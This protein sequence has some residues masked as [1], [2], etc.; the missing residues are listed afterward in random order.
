MLFLKGLPALLTPALSS[1]GRRGEIEQGAGETLSALW[2]EKGGERSEPGEVGPLEAG[3]FLPFSA[4]MTV[5]TAN[6]AGRMTPVAMACALYTAVSWGAT[7][8]FVKLAAVGIDGLSV[9]ILRAV[10][11]LPFALAVILLMGLKL[12][13]QGRHKWVLLY[14]SAVGLVGFILLQSWGASLSTTGHT[15]VVNSSS[16][17]LTG[18]LVALI[19]WRRP[20]LTWVVGCLVAFAGTAL[21]IAEAIGLTASHAS[22]EGDLL[23]FGSSLAAASIFAVS[24]PTMG[25]YG[26]YAVTMWSVVVASL[27]MIPFGLW[28]LDFAAVAGLSGVAWFSIAMLAINSNIVAYLAMFVAIAIAG[29]TR[30]TTFLFG[31]PVVGVASGTLFLGELLTWPLVVATFVIIAGVAL[32]QRGRDQP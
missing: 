27:M 13:W 4:C 30:M 6:G 17:I 18:L 32:A 10:L 21:L 7:P 26:P 24:G 25:R 16:P 23:V 12:P 14:V 29:P 8:L 15:A 3:R 20:K 22:L 9:G 1:H 19:A 2:G 5:A 31:M 28:H 11:S